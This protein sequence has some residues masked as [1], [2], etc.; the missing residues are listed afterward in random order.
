M[1][2]CERREEICINILKNAK[3]KPGVLERSDLVNVERNRFTFVKLVIRRR[4]NNRREDVYYKYKKKKKKKKKN[5]KTYPCLFSSSQILSTLSCISKGTHRWPRISITGR[6]IPS[7]SLPN[8]FKILQTGFSRCLLFPK[9][10]SILFSVA[11]SIRA[12][13]GSCPVRPCFFFLPYVSHH[14]DPSRR[15]G[16]S[17]I[18]FYMSPLI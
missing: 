13:R 1:Y 10:F 7:S 9:R 16:F 4:G 6:R 12:D 18:F 15:R 2:V 17:F 14:F 8:R 3:Q 5:K 11:F